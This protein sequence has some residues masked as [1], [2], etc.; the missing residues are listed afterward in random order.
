MSEPTD[1]QKRALEK[2]WRQQM[3]DR[4]NRKAALSARITPD[5]I[6]TFTKHLFA[7]T[8]ENGFECWPY[9]GSEQGICLKT[10]RYSTLTFN[11][12]RGVQ[13]HRF[14]LAASKGITLADLE[15]YDV[16]HVYGCMGY[17]CSNPAH[18]EARAAVREHR[19]TRGAAG[20]RA[21]YQVG[22][23]E[24]SLALPYAQRYPDTGPDANRRTLA[25]VSFNIRRAT[26]AFIDRGEPVDYR[27]FLE[28]PEEWGKWGDRQ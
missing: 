23:F 22:L 12:V 26:V 16:H 18:H 4:D 11:G 20:S 15:G 8:F 24:A 28:L 6:E 25:E 10:K 5:R 17:S 19:G 27:A 9:S 14:A 13:A 1:K 2:K 21:R 7:I 3:L